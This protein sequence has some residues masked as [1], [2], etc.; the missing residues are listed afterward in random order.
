MWGSRILLDKL[1]KRLH[2]SILNVRI[3]ALFRFARAKLDAS[4]LYNTEKES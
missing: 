3:V 1:T 2:I 4:N